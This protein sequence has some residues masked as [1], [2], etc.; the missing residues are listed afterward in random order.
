MAAISCLFFVVCLLAVFN[1]YSVVS[2]TS[3]CGIAEG[4]VMSAALTSLALSLV[5]PLAFET[6]FFLLIG[7]RN[8]KSCMAHICRPLQIL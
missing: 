4:E 8:K 3:F 5:L 2:C 7:K 6:G 1:S